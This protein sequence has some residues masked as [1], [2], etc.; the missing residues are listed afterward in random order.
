M[1]AIPTLLPSEEFREALRRR[2]GEAAARCYQCATCS[3]VCELARDEAPFPRRLMLWAQWGLA[4]RLA[5]DPAVWLCH[6]CNDCTAR[7]PRDAK[8]GDVVQVIRALV[9]EKLAFPG[10]LGRVV[11]AARTTWPL[12]VGLPIAFWIALLAVTGHFG[13]PAGLPQNWAYEQLV[14]H[15]LIYS[16]FFPAAAWTLLAAWVSGRRFWGL[17]AARGPRKKSFVA[18]LW[19]AGREIATHTRFASCGEAKPRRLGHLSLMWGFVG[20]AVTS[21]LL[22]VGIYIQHLAM[23]LALTHPYKLLGN[24]SAVLLVVGAGVLVANR[25]GDTLKAGAATAFDTYFLTI[26][27][28]VIVTGVLAEVARLGLSPEFAFGTYIVHLGLVLSLFLTFPYSKFAHLLY[29][30]LAMVHEGG[31][32][33]ETARP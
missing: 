22:I 15:L 28:L 21:G 1:A 7:C 25:L 12:L 10:F 23:P 19:P 8:P 24:V 33:A 6:Q 11:G 9:I 20:A 14:P 13:V 30:S 26:V 31:S 32:E 2:G 16:V 18:G 17:L 27:V 5:A 4:E 29:R 3:G